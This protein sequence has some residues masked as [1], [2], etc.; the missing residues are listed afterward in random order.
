MYKCVLQDCF[1]IELKGHWLPHNVMRPDC[2]L[3]MSQAD[4]ENKKNNGQC[5]NVFYFAVKIELKF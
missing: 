3:E 1:K 5:K 4:V 2:G